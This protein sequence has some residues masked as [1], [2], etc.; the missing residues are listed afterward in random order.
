MWYGVGR[1]RSGAGDRT[2]EMPFLCCLRKRT[3]QAIRRGFLRC[4]KRDSDFPFWKRK[5]L[6]S[7]RTNSLPCLQAKSISI[8]HLLPR[9]H[10]HQRHRRR[11]VPES[12]SSRDRA[13]QFSSAGQRGPGSRSVCMR[14]CVC[15]C[16]CVR[17]CRVVGC[18]QSL[19]SLVVMPPK[20]PGVPPSSIVSRK[21]RSGVAERVPFQGRSAGRRRYRRTSSFWR[22]VVDIIVVGVASSSEFKAQGRFSIFFC[23]LDCA[24]IGLPCDRLE[25][26][27]TGPGSLFSGLGGGRLAGKQPGD[28]CNDPTKPGLG[29]SMR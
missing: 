21:S 17:A 3:V 25:A 1:P 5:I 14:A 27:T 7:P 20:T 6:L 11:H 12:G 24:A 13:I 2:S 8:C 10:H 26:R 18:V 23:R 15:V 9:E 22:L 29:A 4:R 28:S 16:V 19:P